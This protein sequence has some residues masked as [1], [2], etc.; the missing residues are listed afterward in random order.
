MII[1]LLGLLCGAIPT[2]FNVTQFKRELFTKL[3]TSNADIEQ[4]KLNNNLSYAIY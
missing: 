2:N 3:K 4:F 1:G